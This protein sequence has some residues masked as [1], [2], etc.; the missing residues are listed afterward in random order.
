[1]HL[2]EV[3]HIAVRWRMA[4]LLSSR[5]ERLQPSATVAVAQKAKALA[6]SGVDV[7]SFSLGEPD[8]G[9]PTHVVDA[10]REAL[11]GDC[12]HYTAAQGTLTLRESICRA[13]LRRRGVA[14]Q[15]SEVIVS[16]GAKHALFNLAM[17]LFEPG[18]EVV[19]PA[20][21][22]VSYPAQ[23]E[24][25]GATPKIVE[26]DA[27]SGFKLTPA[28]L[29]SALSPKTKALVL[30]SPSNPT[31]SAYT[32]DELRA[33]AS[34]L[35]SHDCYIIADEIYGELV[36]GDFA[37]RSL[38]TL[39]PAL[40]ER[41]IIIDG[42]SKSYAMTGWRIGWMLAPE[43]IVKACQ[44]I[45]GQST[46]NPTALAQVAAAAALDGDQAPLASMRDTFQRRRDR[47]V[48]A[49]RE[50]DGVEC[51]LPQGAFYAFPDVRAL[52][53]RSFEG[54]AIATDIDLANYFLDSVGVALVPGTAFGAPGFMRLSYAASD[55]KLTE[56]VSRIA[57]AIAGLTL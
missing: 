8:F 49:L 13:S 16:V 32:E 31:G 39:S 42:V 18:D 24:L 47:V 11:T 3:R 10:A 12:H 34:V 40:R 52:M 1:M 9:P 20:P 15:P 19:V 14:H 54:N 5:V 50:I 53:G 45:Q 38:L 23:V 2:D 17:S 30:C 6:A 56:G 55:A 28:Q 22:W 4:K 27:A 51:H 37:Q 21:Y 44:K 57:K 46:T 48:A 33:L 26:T 35:E 25:A 43:A 36:Y 29:E 41:V 7:L